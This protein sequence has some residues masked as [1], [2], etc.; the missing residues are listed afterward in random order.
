MKGGCRKVIGTLAVFSSWVLFMLLT[1]IQ[2]TAKL[3]VG[4]S[5]EVNVPTRLERTSFGIKSEG[6]DRL[7]QSSGDSTTSPSLSTSI[8]PPVKPTPNNQIQIQGTVASSKSENNKTTN[9]SF[10]TL[11][12][13]GFS[14]PNLSK[15]LFPEY[16]DQPPLL[17]TRNASVTTTTKDLLLFGMHGDCDGSGRK[18]RVSSTHLE[19]HFSGKVLY[20]NGEPRGNAIAWQQSQNRSFDNIYQIGSVE[21]GPHTLRVF[22]LAVV[23]LDDRASHP[24]RRRASLRDAF[25]ACWSVCGETTEH[26]VS[27]TDTAG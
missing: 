19:E 11:F 10:G 1:N 6:P 4:T 3:R 17:Y 5:Q 16:E 12:H 15:S 22:Y 25:G 18:N 20:V 27:T 2:T 26:S 9:E 8:H 7:E 23:L 21:D 14:V 13:C 24:I